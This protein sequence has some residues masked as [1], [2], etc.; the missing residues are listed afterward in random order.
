MRP[1]L[2]LFGL[3]DATEKKLDFWARNIT[4]KIRVG[5]NFHGK[6]ENLCAIVMGKTEGKRKHARLGC[7]SWMMKEVIFK[8]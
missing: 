8:N 7:N 1:I 3:G 6:A 2:Y 5:G 4:S